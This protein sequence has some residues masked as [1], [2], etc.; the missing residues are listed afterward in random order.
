[1]SI[2]EIQATQSVSGPP[3]PP[4]EN[5]AASAQGVLTKYDISC[6]Y[7]TVQ[8]ETSIHL[9][10][11]NEEGFLADIDVQ[12]VPEIPK[13]TLKDRSR[14]VDHFFSPSHQKNDKNYRNCRICS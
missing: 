1:V 4:V 5:S 14:D 6:V 7:S 3:Q 11:I 12:A 2:E 8:K 13:T 9:D 10:A